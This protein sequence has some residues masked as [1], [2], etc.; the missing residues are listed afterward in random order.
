[1]TIAFDVLTLATSRC[2]LIARVHGGDLDTISPRRVTFNLATLDATPGLGRRGEEAL[3]PWLTVR[4][5]AN[6]VERDGRRIRLS[7]TEWQLFAFLWDHPGVTFSRVELATGA[8]GSQWANRRGEV[9]IY[10]SRIRRKVEHD[11][12]HPRVI[13]TVRGFGYRLDRN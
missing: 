8:W 6:T 10:I 2:R 3:G 11:A 1:M 7:W 13:R 4:A 9:E 5:D 12:R